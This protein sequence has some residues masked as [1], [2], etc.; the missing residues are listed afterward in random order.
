VTRGECRLCGLEADLQNSH[1]VPS[2]VYRWIRST[3][4]TGFMRGNAKPNVRM[5]DG[6][7]CA[8]L[9][10][11][12]EQRFSGW[13]REFATRVFHP[14]VEGRVAQSSYGDW[15]L[16]FCVS[17]SWRALIHLTGDMKKEEWADPVVRDQCAAAEQCWRDFLLGNSRHPGPFRQ[18]LL[19]VG[20]IDQ[21]LPGLPDRFNS[22]MQRSTLIDL[23]HFPGTV[24]TLTKMSGLI[25]LGF[26]SLG[27][28]KDWRSQSRVGAQAGVVTVNGFWA[29][30]YFWEYLF[31]QARSTNA[32]DDEISDRQKQIIDRAFL[33][34]PL[35]AITSHQFELYQADQAAQGERS[36]PPET[37]WPDDRIKRGRR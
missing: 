11:G 8:S 32:R 23:C 14:I 29:P 28:E 19:A 35:K 6:V 34:D 36:S 30:P 13:E 4:V 10:R 2:F 9:C 21:P 15:M 22:F 20:L 16:K 1:I 18:H 33:A 37:N 5:Q 31:E 24:Y 3:S 25:V 26:I 17:V 12:C 7:T 27:R